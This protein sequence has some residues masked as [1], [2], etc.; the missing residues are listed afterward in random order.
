M[1]E[2][3]A[4]L[5]ADEREVVLA[6]IRRSCEFKY[7]LLH[8]AHVRSTHV[9]LVVTAEATPEKVMHVL[10][11]YATRALNRRFGRKAKRWATHGSMVRL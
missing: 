6:E 10:K 7:W 3:K 8:A 4:S 5:A 2:A 9:H 11:S 1:T